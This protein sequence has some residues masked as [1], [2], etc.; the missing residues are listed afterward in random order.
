MEIRGEPRFHSNNYRESRTFPDIAK[1]TTEKFKELYS[2]CP[3]IF[4]LD[5][6]VTFDSALLHIYPSMYL[7]FLGI[8]FKVAEIIHYGLNCIPC[9]PKSVC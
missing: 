5:S 1:R 8:H 9:L 7:T 4:I 3:Y 2:E 6:T